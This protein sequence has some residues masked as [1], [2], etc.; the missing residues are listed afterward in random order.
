M[1]NFTGLLYKDGR[2]D[3][4]AKVGSPQTIHDVSVKNNSMFGESVI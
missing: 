1:A 3:V 2:V 4:I